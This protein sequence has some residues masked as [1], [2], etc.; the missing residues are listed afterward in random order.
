MTNNADKITPQGRSV[1]VTLRMEAAEKEFMSE[2]VIGNDK[3]M[4][5]LREKLHALLDAKLDVLAEIAV[6]A[7]EGKL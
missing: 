7:R 2:A 3:G 1:S 5:H 6:L 4:A